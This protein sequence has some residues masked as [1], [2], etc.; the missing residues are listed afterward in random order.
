[1]KTRDYVCSRN[2]SRNDGSRA[3]HIDIPVG[4]RRRKD[5][6][7]IPDSELGNGGISGDITLWLVGWGKDLITA[8]PHIMSELAEGKRGS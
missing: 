7:R 2:K 8:G 5:S 3:L 1:M 4:M 6:A